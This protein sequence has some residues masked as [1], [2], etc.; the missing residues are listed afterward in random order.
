MITWELLGVAL[1]VAAMLLVCWAVNAWGARRSLRGILG[2]GTPGARG[3]G[4]CRRARRHRRPLD[5][6][7]LP[8]ELRGYYS[9]VCRRTEEAFSTAPHDAVHQLDLL[10]SEALRQCGYPVDTLE[11]DLAWVLPAAPEVVEDYR[12]A[13]A[14]ALG[15][16]GGIASEPDLRLAMFHYHALLKSL[17]DDGGPGHLTRAGR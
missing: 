7:P 8:A 9:D 13:H 16:D 11:H 1:I 17:L 14:I 10:A 4:R 6:R 2:G 3:V 5:I 12:S 15:D